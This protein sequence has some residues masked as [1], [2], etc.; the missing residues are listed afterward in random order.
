MLV[1]YFLKLLILQ[2]T[3]HLQSV[4][5]FETLNFIF[6]NTMIYMILI[7]FLLFIKILTYNELQLCTGDS[8][9]FFKCIISF[10][11][12]HGK[13]SPITVSILIMRKWKL[14]ETRWFTQSIGRG[15][16]GISHSAS[17][18]PSLCMCVCVCVCVCV[19]VTQWRPTLFDPMDCSPPDSSVRGILQARIPE[20]V[21]MSFSR[22]SAWPRDWIQ[23]SCIAG[24]FFTIRAT[25]EAPVCHLPRSKS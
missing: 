8:T 12:Q 19:W 15:F 7:C 1:K 24:R 23:V 6:M 20:W 14:G 5:L 9:K 11:Q 17:L 10:L 3:K 21:A 16:A 22:G 4:F 13:D 2:R 25:R 18:E